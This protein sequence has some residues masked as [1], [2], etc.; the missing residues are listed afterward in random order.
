MRKIWYKLSNSGVKADMLVETSRKII[1]T[2]QLAIT[3]FLLLISMN[4]AFAFTNFKFDILSFAAI[5]SLLTVP[6]FNKYGNYKLTTFFVSISTPLCT[7]FFSAYSKTNVDFPVDINFYIFPKLLLISFFVLPL[8]LIDSKAK[9]FLYFALFINLVS[10]FAVDWV[11][12]LFGVD[13]KLVNVTYTFYHATNMLFF[14]PILIIV[15]GF[16]FLNNINNKYERKIL[17]LLGEVREKNTLLTEQNEE[18]ASQRDQIIQ[19]KDN[20][21]KANIK[22]SRI[23]SDLTNSIVYA[24]RIQK[25][26]LPDVE[27]LKAYFADSFIFYKAKSIVSGD[28]YFIK[29]S[30]VNQ[31]ECIVVAAADCTGHGVPGGFMSM[32]GVTFLNEIVR[33][34]TF[35]DAADILNILRDNI[36]QAL[37]QTGKFSD[38]KDGM[39]MALC[40]YYPNTKMLDFAGAKNPLYIIENSKEVNI[41]KPDRMPIGVYLKEQ[42]FTNQSI[43]LKGGEYLYMFSDGI[44][45]QMDEYG[46]KYM[47]KNFRNYLLSIYETEAKN[48]EDK[49]NNEMNRWRKKQDGT[50]VE[51]LDDMLVIGLKI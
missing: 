13:L 11:H 20:L 15:F 16:L 46:K 48:Q 8:I 45:D 10:F 4:F 17:N 29:T 26:I 42:P 28:F 36:K 43:Q 30:Q 34:N 38:Q 6:L 7:L 50:L 2:N 35:S 21:E 40:I 19:Q 18:I 32:L 27:Q 9:F 1:L 41:Y 44:V 3:A 37:N 12:W 51:Q 31:Q 33:D 47:S 24:E 23:N 14:V 49:L 25:A 39:D 5:S 22:I